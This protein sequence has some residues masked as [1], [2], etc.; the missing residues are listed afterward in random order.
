M[1]L[2][3]APDIGIRFREP[4]KDLG[5]HKVFDRGEEAGVLFAPMNTKSCLKS[6]PSVLVKNVERDAVQIL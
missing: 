6:L 3:G 2:S 5:A 1:M 4:K